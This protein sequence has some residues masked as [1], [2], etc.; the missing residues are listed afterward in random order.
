MRVQKYFTAGIA[1]LLFL[2][3]V[4]QVDSFAKLTEDF[5]DAI[6]DGKRS[7]K[8]A[9]VSDSALPFVKGQDRN[10]VFPV[11]KSYEVNGLLD[12]YERVLKVAVIGYQDFRDYIRLPRFGKFEGRQAERGS[13]Q[14]IKV[15]LAE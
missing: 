9:P 15:R 14:D 3:F 11:G 10:D 6:R 7:Y 2:L 12:F 8:E 13:Y 1:A 5:N 4:A